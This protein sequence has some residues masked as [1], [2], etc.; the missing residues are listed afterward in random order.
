MKSTQAELLGLDGSEKVIDH[1]PLGDWYDEEEKYE[2]D[3]NDAF[4]LDHWKEPT[5]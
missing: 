2:S 4:D 3:A 5:L 1:E